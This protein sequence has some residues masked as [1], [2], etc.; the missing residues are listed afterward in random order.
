M[1]GRHRNAAPSSI[2]LRASAAAAAVLVVL[3]GSWFAFRNTAEASCGSTVPLTV[4]AAAEIVP[5]LQ[6]TVAEFTKT[7][8]VGGRC[9]KVEVY[10]ADSADLAA[11]VAGQRGATLTGVGAPGSKVKIPDVWI[12]DSTSWLQRLRAAGQGLVPAEAPSVARS[13]IA[14][15]APEPVAASLG[16]PQVK[17]TYAN[18]LKKLSTDTKLKVGVVEPTRDATGLSGLLTMGAA[19][20][21]TGA[22]AQ[23]TSTAALRSFASGRAVLRD[24]LLRRFPRASDATSLAGGLSLAPLSEQAIWQYNAAQP[25]VPL[26][27]LYVEPEP[28]ALDYP[29]TVLPAT[30]GEKAGAAASL[31]AAL[32]GDGYRD[33]LAAVGLRAGDSSIGKGFAPGA[34]A[35][36]GTPQPAPPP[37]AT[38][39]E[40]VLSSWTAI[41]LPARMLAVLDVSGSMKQLVPTAGNASRMVVTVEAARRGMA[42]FDDS[43]ALGLWVFS[44]ELEGDKDYRQLVPIGPLT[45]QRPA[46]LQALTTVRPKDQG[47]TGLYDT[48]LAGYKA[49][50]DGWDPGRVNS[51][52]IMTD[53][54]NDDAKG[55]SLDQLTA[56]LEKTID[57]TKP[58]Q[59]ILIGIGSTVGQ[60]E[61]ERVTKL[62]GG[63]TFV[64]PDPAKIGEIFLKAIALRTTGPTK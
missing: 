46:L 60:A 16:Y 54:E 7:A 51:L 5:A 19:T 49:V 43:W 35:P 17:L 28:I 44:T 20:S 52:M 22:A 21:A 26:V 61:M 8:R 6:A 27:A 37:D 3:A 31:K 15:A 25:P 59:V 34:G 33:R 45:T 14:L 53:G 11:L 18:L 1:K 58:I 50:Q 23:Q 57:K 42:L 9:V 13:P 29:F 64:A 62:T 4:G 55:I 32:T 38:S 40:R 2:A 41:T 47:D 36:T 12:P 24:E 56:E 30:A 63:G 39:I 10:A 48:I